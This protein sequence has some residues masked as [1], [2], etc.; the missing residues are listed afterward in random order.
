M[1]SRPLAAERTPEMSL[2][3]NGDELGFCELIL[4]SFDDWA[5]SV[6]GEGDCWIL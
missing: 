6:S 5:E 4:R 3:A 1:V 2:F